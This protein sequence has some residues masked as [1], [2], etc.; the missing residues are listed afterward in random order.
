MA[1][2]RDARGETKI[3]IA[4]A[5]PVE[6]AHASGALVSRIARGYLWFEEIC[7]G[8]TVRVQDI[9]RREGVTDRYV[10]RLMEYALMPPAEI[11]KILAGQA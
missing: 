2:R 6:L 5:E 8:Q 10:S 11:E 9:A 4:G 7:S 3:A 1:L